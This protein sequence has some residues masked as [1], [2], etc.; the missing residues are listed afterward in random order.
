MSRQNKVITVKGN[1]N[2]VAT[3]SNGTTVVTQ[4]GNTVTTDTDDN[5]VAVINGT[6]YINGQRV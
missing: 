6:V 3:G 4:D 2:T 1:G 5:S